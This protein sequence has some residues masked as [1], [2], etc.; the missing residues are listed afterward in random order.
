MREKYD[1][2]ADVRVG[3]GRGT[4]GVIQI[5]SGSEATSLGY[6]DEACIV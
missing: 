2:V 1:A 3:K 4:H 6:G 5:Q